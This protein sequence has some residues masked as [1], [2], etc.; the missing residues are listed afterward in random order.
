MERELASRGDASEWIELELAFGKDGK[1]G[2]FPLGDGRTLGVFGRTD[3][4]DRMPDGGLRVIDYKTGKSTRFQKSAKKA[5]FDGGR[6]LQPPLYAA[7]VE[8]LTRR[9]VSRFEYR[10]PT[11]RG[12]SEIVG[13]DAAELRAAA[14]IVRSLLEQ[15][16]SGAFPPTNDPADCSYCDCSPICRARQ[17]G[18]KTTSPRAEWGKENSAQLDVYQIMRALRAI[19]GTAEE[20]A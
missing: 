10:F 13:Y 7:A 2:H 8:A 11:A 16:A 18:F 9:K 12:E 3:R 1:A 20:Q 14:P 17:D 5:P 19:G 6:Q 4:V 15:A